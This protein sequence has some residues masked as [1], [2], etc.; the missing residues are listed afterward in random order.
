VAIAFVL[1]CPVA[2]YIMNQWL[3]GFEY[4]TAL[5]AGVFVLAGFLVLVLALITVSYQS[6]KAAMFNPIDSLKNE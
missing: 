4:R 6:L 3:S 5:S 2:W 1:A